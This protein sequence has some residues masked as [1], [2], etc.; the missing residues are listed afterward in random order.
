VISHKTN[1]WK[2]GVYYEGYRYPMCYP[3]FCIGNT[4]W[5]GMPITCIVHLWKSQYLATGKNLCSRIGTQKRPPIGAIGCGSFKYPHRGRIPTTNGVKL[6]VVGPPTIFYLHPPTQVFAPPLQFRNLRK[7]PEL[8]A[9]GNS[10]VSFL[11]NFLTP[12]APETMKVFFNTAAL[13]GN[14]SHF[15]DSSMSPSRP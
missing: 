12:E 14:P 1:I 8:K 7:Y 10:I 9:I 13:H 6:W 3:L 15:Q 5:I 2:Y 4:Q 11:Y